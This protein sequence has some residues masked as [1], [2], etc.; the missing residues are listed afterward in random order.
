MC[1]CND[2]K[3]KESIALS[4]LLSLLIV[5][6]VLSILVNALFSLGYPAGASAIERELFIGSMKLE[7]PKEFPSPP[8]FIFWLS[9]HFLRSQNQE[10][11]SSVY[12]C[13]E[14][15]RERLLRRLLIDYLVSLRLLKKLQVRQQWDL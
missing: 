13:S 10:S 4:T 8:S 14:R 1:L 7:F 9:L 2:G 15:A 6:R 11:C 12:L 5:P 3:R